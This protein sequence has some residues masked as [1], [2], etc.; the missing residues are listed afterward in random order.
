[1]Y[2]HEAIFD[3]AYKQSTSLTVTDV[4]M[5]LGY[6]AVE[7]EHKL[8]GL[9]YSFIKEITPASCSVLKEAGSL[10]GEK[11]SVLLNGIFSYNLTAASLAIAAANA[12]LNRHTQNTDILNLIEKNDK[13]VMIGYFGPLIPIIKQNTDNLI[14]CERDAKKNVMP[15]YAA[16]FELPDA[17]VVLISAT[18]LINKTIDGLLSRIKK[19]RINAI[20]GPSCTMEKAVFKNTCITHLCGT[21]VSDIEQAKVIISEGGGTVNLKQVTRKEC[22]CLS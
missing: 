15:D 22:L 21:T 1:M 3:A 8:L 18:T 2:I 13:V 17:D 16:Y 6:T 12:I 14:I 20:I 9:S 10:I 11:A 19:S 7:L 4:R 5:G